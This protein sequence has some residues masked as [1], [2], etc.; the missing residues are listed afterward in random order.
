MKKKWGFVCLEMI[1]WLVFAGVVGMLY[2][3]VSTLAS[4]H[5]AETFEAFLR[6]MVSIIPGLL[7]AIGIGAALARHTRFGW[8]T[9]F[10]ISAVSIPLLIVPWIYFLFCFTFVTE[11]LG[12]SLENAVLILAVLSAPAVYGTVRWILKSSMRKIS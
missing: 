1:G 3:F 2:V 6:E 10:G 5:P 4:D 8:G 11:W 12:I 7:I 9:I